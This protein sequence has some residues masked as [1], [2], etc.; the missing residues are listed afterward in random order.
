VIPLPFEVKELTEDGVI[1]G[2]AS[3]TDLDEVG[4]RVLPGA[5]AKSVAANPTVPMLW[6]HDTTQPIGVWDMLTENTRGLYAKGRL[7]LSV[8]KAKEAFDLLKAGA[9]TGLSIGFQT[10]RAERDRKTGVRMLKEILLREVSLVTFPA[11]NSARL[12]SVKASEIAE[13]RDYE[14]FL[15]EAGFSRERAKLLSK[16]FCTA[17]DAQRDAERTAVLNAAA[18]IRQRAESIS[19][20]RT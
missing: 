11:N 12:V 13:K 20:M 10:K 9:V 17:D 2:W 14:R 15:R 3:T 1:E 8:A 5:F 16:G 4:D 18:A 19:K 7:V 6:A